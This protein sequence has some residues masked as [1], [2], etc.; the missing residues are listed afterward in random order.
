MKIMNYQ[1]STLLINLSS[2]INSIVND[3]TDLTS[4]TIININSIINKY[5]SSDILVV[6]SD[7]YA[8]EPYAEEF[9]KITNLLE[10]IGVTVLTTSPGNEEN[11]IRNVINSNSEKKTIV[12]SSN[13]GL[14]QL[15]NDN[16]SI[17]NTE[18]S[19]EVNDQNFSDYYNIEPKMAPALFALNKVNQE[20]KLNIGIKTLEKYL[21]ASNGLSGLIN[22]LP[23]ERNRYVKRLVDH[24][25]LINQYHN[26]SISYS[27]LNL[28]SL[29][30]SRKPANVILLR[31]KLVEYNLDR[32]IFK[33]NHI[34][35]DINDAQIVFNNLSKNKHILINPIIK[36][37][38]ILAITIIAPPEKAFTFDL[39]S[40][41]KSLN[42]KVFCKMF[43]PLF[44]HEGIKKLCLNSKKLCLSLL[45]SDIELTNIV[46]DP[47]QASYTFDSSKYSEESGATLESIYQ[48]IMQSPMGKVV[49]PHDIISNKTL[50]LINL[51]EQ[52][53]DIFNF[54]VKL[55][56]LMDKREP[57]TSR[58]YSEFESKLNLILAKME[59]NGL[60][61]DSQ[62][63]E[64]IKE[65]SIATMISRVKTLSYIFKKPFSEKELQLKSIK[66]LLINDLELVKKQAPN[67]KN[68]FVNHLKANSDI[69]D[70][71][72]NGFIDYLT[73]S[74]LIVDVNKIIGKVKNNRV[75]ANFNHTKTKTFRIS[76][77]DPNVQGFAKNQVREGIVAKENNYIVSIDYSQFELKILAELSGDPVLINAFNKGIDIHI[78]TASKVFEIPYNDV[79][80][81]QRKMAK[82]INFGL[83]YGKEAFSLASD[84]GTTKEEAQKKIDLYFTKF[85]TVKKFL[86][87][88]VISAKKEG[89]VR[90]I[91]GRRIS[92]E[93]ITSTNKD[94]W[95]LVNKAERKS[96]NAPM[97]GSA[98]DIMKK[99]MVNVAKLISEKYPTV[100]MTNQI[101]DELLFDVPKDLVT[102]F[103][104]E[105]KSIMENV[106]SLRVPLTVDVE[107]GKNWHN[108]KLIDMSKYEK[109]HEEEL[110]V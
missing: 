87:N 40:N 89:A 102:N 15:I 81:H 85:P 10:T 61:V 67:D 53:L 95:A 58:Y 21:S 39:F 59:Y 44:E 13:K 62:R 35:S 31:Q 32:S 83:I 8:A 3:T 1:N 30:I 22:S 57:E 55:K 24:I 100:I 82:A 92:I 107:V 78:E 69:K 76:A 27:D 70:P 16:L 7:H 109:T 37:N 42:E 90:T 63:L 98:A 88:L 64:N 93:Y 54:C 47:M 12:C 14:Y 73:S 56:N 28:G 19:I 91:T 36:D 20:N 52:T 105:A 50:G 23:K 5:N 72:I 46:F 110:T 77:N 74:Q 97:Q 2:I 6:S 99:A 41:K 75:Y 71:I 94:D 18:D 96:K 103:C 80:E 108:T 51:G 38:E 49:G 9:D 29:D 65:Q 4:D 43:K 104:L 11:L 68:S 26:E 84:L 101:H 33:E 48:T 86:D 66:E 60:G 45:N 79:T 34:I 17:Y 25:D 106:V